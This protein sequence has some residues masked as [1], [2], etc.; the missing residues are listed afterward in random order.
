M[1]GRELVQ[2]VVDDGNIGS[3][4]VIVDLRTGREIEP[5]SC[6]YNYANHRYEVEV[7]TEP[8]GGE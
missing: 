6:G 2:V 1:S 7:E 5:K 8:D 4:V 3:Q